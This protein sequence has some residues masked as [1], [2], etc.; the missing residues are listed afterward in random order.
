MT[1]SNLSPMWPVQ[2]FTVW[3][4]WTVR[5]FYRYSNAGVI[6][7]CSGSSVTVTAQNA[8]RGR[9]IRGRLEG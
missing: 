2:R 4:M 9:S 8:P 3:P 6:K 5:C 1:P 7:R